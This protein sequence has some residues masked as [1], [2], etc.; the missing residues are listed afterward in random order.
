[1]HSIRWAALSC[2][3]AAVVTGG[4]FFGCSD[5][6]STPGGE[7]VTDVPKGPV[8]LPF[9]VSE[10]F[11][12]SGFMGEPKEPKPGVIEG[13][14]ISPSDCRSDRKAEAAGACYKI[15]FVPVLTPAGKGWGGMYWQSPTNNWGA[16][17]GKQ[18]APGAK[19][20]RFFAAGAK[21]G[22]LVKFMAGGID[23][24]DDIDD[25]D[26]TIALPYADTLKATMTV[27]L[28]TE[29]TEYVL[30]LGDQNYDRVL[31][32]FAWSMDVTTTD[33]ISFYLDN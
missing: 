32:G 7:Q 3:T 20:V 9:L 17:E 2:L 24:K 4:V 13:L 11:A 18:I 10:E 21:G 1:M 28:T 19:R 23:D 8:P 29:W 16:V 26:P 6:A 25:N 14:K 27:T 15:D 31:G 30:E 12:P 5:N 22:E 33:P